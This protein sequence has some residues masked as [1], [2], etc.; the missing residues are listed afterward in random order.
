MAG[1]ERYVLT[2]VRGIRRWTDCEALCGTFYEGKLSE[3]LNK[4]SFDVVTFCGKDNVSS[5]SKIV[6]YVRERGIDVIHMIDLKSTIIGAAC[7][8][9]LSNV[10]TVS[11]M[12]GLPEWP[13]SLIK[14]IKYGTTL[15]PYYFAL[16]CLI[17]KTVM[18]SNDLSEKMGALLGRRRVEVIHNGIDVE[19]FQGR[20]DSIERKGDGFVLGAVGRLDVVKGYSFLLDAAQ[21][22]SSAG[23]RFIVEIIGAGPL[24]QELKRKTREKDLEGRIHFLGF[25]EDVRNR[26]ANMDIF[27]MPS[28]HEGIPYVLLEAMALGKP[29]VCSKVGGIREIVEDQKDG[30]LV[31]PKNPRELANTLG[32]L[33]D[34][35]ESARAIGERAKEKVRTMFSA[36]SMVERTAAVYRDLARERS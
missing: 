18:V 4:Q 16:R 34:N 13:D 29:V 27:V 25:R 17:D 28:L 23:R 32:M 31:S 15:I 35:W 14:A 11:T 26:I 2:L 1:A 8:V 33:M 5:L 19:G 30:L 24:E 21:E 7:S 9:F 20:W 6:S 22:L 36:R 10:K 12:H 3:E